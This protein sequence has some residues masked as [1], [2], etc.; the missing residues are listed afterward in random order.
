MLCGS[1]VAS[2]SCNTSSVAICRYCQILVMK[3]G[4]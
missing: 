4:Y 1:Y 3:P 2:V